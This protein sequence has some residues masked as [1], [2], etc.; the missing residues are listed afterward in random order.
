MR[1]RRARRAPPRPT[2]CDSRPPGTARRRTGVPGPECIDVRFVI[3]ADVGG[4]GARH[5]ALLAHP[6]DCDGRVET[7]GKGDT[8]PLADR[9]GRQDLAHWVSFSVCLGCGSTRRWARWRARL[10]EPVGECAAADRVAADQEHRVVA[11]DRADT[12]LA[13][14]LVERG[15]Q[16]AG[17]PRAGCA[18][19]RGW[20]TTRR[21]TSS[22]S[23]SLA[24]RLPPPS[25]PSSPRPRSAVAALGGNGVHQDAPGVPDPH[26]VELDQVAGSGAWVTASPASA[27]SS[28]SSACDRTAWVDSRSAMWC[29]RAAFVVAIVVPGSG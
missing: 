21:E 23:Q 10:E 24:S 20:R 12:T 13:G 3:L 18:A 2:R 14:G 9:Q 27:S 25:P 28:A 1:R 16:E 5:R 22:S 4:V 8:D 26:R 17:R 6:G 15:R 29:W 7:A 19:R 11:G